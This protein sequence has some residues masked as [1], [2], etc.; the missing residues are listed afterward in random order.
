MELELLMRPALKAALDRL[1]ALLL[2]A[3]A[4]GAPQIALH[5]Q[6]AVDP[7]QELIS[8]AEQKTWHE[9]QRQKTAA[10]YQRYLE[11]FPTGQYAEEAFRLLIER[12]LEGRPVR[13]LIDVEPP[14]TPGGPERRRAIAAAA[15]SLY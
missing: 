15:L 4:G 12:S 6:A 5:A 3:A 10:A 9:A 8:A 11:L 2:A 1:R 13:R 14:L 7:G